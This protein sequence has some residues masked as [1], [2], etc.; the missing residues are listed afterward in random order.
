M[1]RSL[2]LLFTLLFL[3]N[4]TSQVLK[5]QN[6]IDVLRYS[7]VGPYGDSR[8]MAMGGS[9]G[10]LGANL[11]CMSYNPAGIAMYRNGEFDFTP[12]F[13]LQST[14]ATHYGST[15]TGSTS[16]LDIANFG[17]V[18]SWDQNNPNPPNSS[19]YKKWNQRNAFGFN[20]NRLADFNFTTTIDGNGTNTSMIND[21]VSQANANGGNYPSNLNPIY[22]GLAY[23]TGLIGTVTPSDSSHYLGWQLPNGP[24]H[25]TKTINESGYMREAALSF[26]HA[27]SDQF[28]LGATIG[29]DKLNYTRNSVYQE[30]MPTSVGPGVTPY[31]GLE[32]D[33]TLNTA[34]NGYNLKV[35]GIYRVSPSVRVG[36]YVHTPTLLHLTDNYQYTLTATYDT[37]GAGP[38]TYSSSSQ[39]GAYSY[40]VITPGRVGGSVA[41][42]FNRLLA[43]NVDLEYVNYSAMKLGTT[44]GTTAFN[45]TNSIIQSKYSGTMN[46]RAGAELNIR[47]VILRVGYAGYGSPFG[48]VAVGQ[49]VRS[50]FS[51]GVGFR[52]TS[53]WF[54]DMGL[55]YSHWSDNYYLYSAQFVKPTALTNSIIYFTG[56]LGVKFK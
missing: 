40:K 36:F 53:N 3:S 13:R 50:N 10:A 18:K 1:N 21:F 6:D 8:F 5:G 54:F 37:V 45:S 25:Q 31:R 39:P 11:S 35:G 26:A 27:F 41:Y 44:D 9:F 33:E 29:F 46:I 43:T 4:L 48:A 42:I 52:G 23:Q 34:G 7:Q 12:G 30:A 17:F 15:N 14:D 20:W 55:I 51:A 38:F 24:I 19:A 49:F 2:R 16:K 56:T 47:P 32:Y 22:E 28:Y